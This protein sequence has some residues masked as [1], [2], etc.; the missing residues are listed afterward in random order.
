MRRSCVIPPACVVECRRDADEHECDD[1]C[2][3]PV[4]RLVEEHREDEADTG[5][6][7]ERRHDDVRLACGEHVSLQ[8]RGDPWYTLSV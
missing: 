2:D 6:K 5:G 7:P 4:L 8:S 3:E 1:G